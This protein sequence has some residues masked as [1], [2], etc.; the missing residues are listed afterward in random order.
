MCTVFYSL[1]FLVRQTFSNKITQTL[2]YALQANCELP[3]IVVR[4][5]WTHYG[6]PVEQCDI[7]QFQE[8]LKKSPQVLSVNAP[9]VESLWSDLLKV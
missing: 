8:D 2:L 5:C 6:L 9:V 1:G 3:N 7:S 4:N